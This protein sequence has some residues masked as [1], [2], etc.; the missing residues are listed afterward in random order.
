MANI[1]GT[2]GN[3]TIVGSNDNDFLAGNSGN[4]SITG[5]GGNDTVFGD[6]GND[7][8]EGGAG[9]DSLSGGGGQ[10]DIVF[11]EFG[12]A[13]ADV[14]ASF[15][16]AWDRIQ[17]D[18]AAFSAIGASGRFAAGDV[19]FFA[20]AGATAGHDA[21][22]RIIYNTSTGQLFY[23]ADGN[24]AGSAQLIAT[25]QGAPALTAADINVF[26]TPTPS[27]TA[28]NG[29]EG[30]DSIMGTPNDDTI[31]GLGGDDTIDG[32]AG[33]DSITG[34]AGND[35]L[36]GSEGA[37][38]LIGGD[39]NDTL[40]GS[41]FRT[42]LTGPESMDGGLG[43]DLFITEDNRDTIIDAGGVDTVRAFNINWTL[44]PGFENL[45][46]WNGE[47]ESR[48]DGIGNDQNNLL[49]G[50]FGWHVFLDGRA[51]DDTIL[52]SVQ[53]DTLLGGD[54]N[55]FIDSGQDFDSIDGGAGDDTLSGG[56]GGD[57]T[58]TGGAGA[59]HFR[60][61]G[62][63][64]TIT[65]FVAGTDKLELDGRFLARTGPNG[66]F[67]PN[68]D[69]F[70]A[71]AGATD[72]HDATDRVIY[73]TTTGDVYYDPD[74]AGGT[75]AQR[76]TDVAGLT[77]TDITVVNGNVQGSVINGTAGDD[78]LMGTPNDDTIN[79]LGGNDTID[80]AGGD[81]VLNGGDGNDSII[82]IAGFDTVTGGAGNDTIQANGNAVIDGGTGDDTYF[83]PGGSG[84]TL[85]DAGGNDT[86]ITRSMEPLPA[87][88]ENLL[89]RDDSPT[90]FL[91][92]VGNDLDNLIRNES[93]AESFLDGADGND[94]L[95][96]STSKDHFAFSHGSGA[97]GND[98]VDGGAGVDDIT[99]GDFSAAVVDFRS[100]TVVGGGN[101]G[102]G[103]V[104]FS[105]IE[106]ATG[107]QFNDRLI[108]D[109][110][111]RRLS[112]GIGGDDTLIGGAGNDTMV[113]L[114]F[115]SGHDSI[116][117]GGG[118]NTLEVYGNFGATVD[119][120]AGTLTL[121]PSNS[122]TFTNIQNYL[123][124][125]Y[126]ADSIRGSAANNLLVGD[127]GIGNSGNDT[128]DGLGGNDTLTGYNGNDTFLFTVAP[129]EANADLIT[130]FTRD[131][132]KIVLDGIV[133]LNSGPSGNFVANDARFYAAAGATG[134]HDADDRVIYDTS[135]GNLYWDGDGSGAGV[136]QRIATVQTTFS[137][138]SATDIAIINGSFPGSIN[139]TNGD[140]SLVGT[141]GDD[142]MNGFG[143]ND[144]ISGLDG[145]DQ[146]N[147]GTG[148]DSMSGG[149][150]NDTFFLVLSTNNFGHDT[151]DGGAGTDRVSFSGGG[152]GPLVVDLAAGT[153]VEDGNSA[154][155]SSIED[156]DGTVF[157]DSITGNAAANV[158]YGSSGNDT[159][160]GAGGDDQL[161][162]GPGD[163]SMVGGDGNDRFR[164]EGGN[165]TMLG[166]AGDDEYTVDNLNGNYVFDGGAGFDGLTYVVAPVQSG[167]TVDLAAGSASGGGGSGTTTLISVER[168]VGSSFADNLHGDGGNNQLFGGGGD[169]TLN[170]GGGFNLLVGDT[171]ADQFVFSDA[172][173]AGSLITDF[174]SGSDKLHLDARVMTQLGTTGNFAA[175]D[176][177]FYAAAG[178]T[179][180]HDADDRVVYDT[181]NGTLYYD[182]DGSGAGA[183][184][185][186]STVQRDTLPATLSAAD[187]VV[188]NGTT[189]TPT[190][191]P[192]QFISGTSG[193]DSLVG[194]SG[195]DTIFGN[196][197]NDTLD[198]G[199]GNDSM[200]GGGGQDT[201]V[202]HGAGAA[203]ADTVASFDTAWDA[204]RL[205]AAG[206]SSIGSAG[207]FAGGDVRFYAAAGATIGHDA[208]DRI[209][210]NTSTGQLFY[211]ADGNGSG[212]AQ[213]I[214][215]FQ[216]APTIAA[217]DITV[218]GTPSPTPT[219]G[220]INGTEGN[221]SLVGT[222]GDDTINGF[223]GNDTIDG[224]AGADSMV[225]GTGD[226]LYFV[227][228]LGDVIVEAQNGGID[229][230]RE[231]LNNYTLPAW[232]NNLTLL[233]GAAVGQGNDID[234]VIVGNASANSLHG[235]GGNDSLVGGAGDDSLWGA[236]DNDT[237]VGGDGNDLLGGD[238]GNDSMSGGAGTD[239]FY[240]QI[241]AGGD[242]GNDTVDGGDN[243]DWMSFSGGGL[244]SGI[245]AD[246]RTGTIV[247]G[248][249]NGV[250]S[251]SFTSIENIQGSFLD[252]RITGDNGTNWLTGGGGGADT[253]NG[254]LGTDMLT[255]GVGADHFVFD[256]SPGGSNYDAIT[257]FASGEDKI[258][259]DARAMSAL[260]ASG[261]FAAGDARFYAAAGATGGHDAD[262]RVIF[263]TS[264]GQ[265][266][267]DADG[268]GISA[269]QLLFT[270]QSGAAVA[271]TDIVVDNG[272]TPPPTTGQN[273][274][275]STAADTLVGG[276]G[277]DTIY[278]NAG[279]DWI[280]G[281]G[282]N[283]I[284]SG[285]GGQDSYVFREYGAANADTV[286]SFDTAWDAMRF[287][288]AAFTGAGG[289]GHFATGDARF[290]AAAGASSG[291]DAD[292]RFVYN[293]S[294]GQLYYDADGAGGNDAQL[295]ATV[296]GAPTVTANDIWII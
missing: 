160:V 237:L 54:G 154:A 114:Y 294:T 103:S 276:S 288:S 151:I 289:V 241:N 124:S 190:P 16:T 2:T 257:D 108:A 83:L 248:G 52:G 236:A 156:V 121:P 207:R 76:F 98:T 273:I 201:Y 200:S 100:G 185:V 166:G 131:A 142:N 221:D 280:E 171:G 198:G 140:D 220:T 60:V 204:L 141:S 47:V 79:G 127:F 264:T 29:T 93:P 249:L 13:N 163:D 168:V 191:T 32:N 287:D 115:N 40:D 199:A 26:G 10:D 243:S 82:A 211:D 182:A 217:G 41:R 165:D 218:F 57:D 43:N 94:R 192:G 216:G 292:D 256:V 117:G 266:F 271:A 175:G 223:G 105:N 109:D 123:G 164:D 55:D 219:P 125:P 169:D 203:T 232:V 246:M 14:V 78:S 159:L 284:V 70:Y 139:G 215:T 143:G 86:I 278:G 85:S 240:F 152:S 242:Y 7:W 128:I 74:G 69:R 8:L 30:N 258:N 233:G 137:T 153:L 282:G 53:E 161:Q 51:G 150:G 66:Q 252:D 23:D 181:N 147:G 64:N 133:H 267:Y 167:V 135:T 197:G 120:T 275:G 15:A 110:G 77:A 208:D 194:G 58:I 157:N 229:E 239:N 22:D 113:V 67:A 205:D 84:G 196:A 63:F 92:G 178:A 71:A 183:A 102:S 283:D 144:T 95:I 254:S 17:L 28:I 145:N 1:S 21:D 4:D 212:S 272:T 270:V 186:I 177:R 111:G 36:I 279:N 101:A 126:G 269:G 231:A 48:R 245:V 129:G 227:D 224:L 162:G 11:R 281:R 96:G 295:V 209:V 65:D 49:D 45:E 180:G 97:I 195:N 255:G 213:L 104:S 87:G 285:G 61:D 170:G 116:D 179:G 89:L 130:D 38:T 259:L 247:G 68:D 99:V 44:A 81:D 39:G 149:N 18:V 228:N 138:I 235:Y 24:G 50:T 189:P 206:F 134:G 202:F 12:A 174:A 90:S 214:A 176:A 37:D 5:G 184:Q 253:L 27:P 193:N 234:N 290:Y 260:G 250:G 222:A 148:D 34:G 155:L 119:L 19:R 3:D 188:D 277:N 261:N 230:V 20:G 9:N 73:N 56:F 122:A 35:S 62:A 274:Q 268:S 59:D 112:G 31:N 238:E 251:V 296:Q 263:N 72:A 33:N 262:D 46:I 75:A 6:A 42:D 88:I 107:G 158:L 106:I 91:F 146:I 118:N 291:H 244:R 293:T 172:L 286:T 132:D 25:L 80:G 225:G 187:I 210:Y 226:D 136:A 265:L 173:G